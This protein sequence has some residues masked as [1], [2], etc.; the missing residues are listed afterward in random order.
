MNEIQ[1]TIL[2]EETFDTPE[3]AR[4]FVNIMKLQTSPNVLEFKVLERNTK[5]YILY[6]LL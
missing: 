6:K 1:W 4:R 5:F 3:K 2:S